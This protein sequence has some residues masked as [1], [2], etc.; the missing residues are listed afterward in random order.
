MEN[1][2]PERP[3]DFS[4]IAKSVVDFATRDKAE[5]KPKKKIKKATKR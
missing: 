2:K 5:D 4:Q 1:K 3:K